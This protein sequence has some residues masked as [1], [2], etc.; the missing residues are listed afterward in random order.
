MNKNLSHLNDTQIHTLMKRYYNEESVSLLLEEF[1]IDISPS[2]LFKLFPPVVYNE[3]FCTYCP[4][5]NLA[6]E[7]KSR[8]NCYNENF[9]SEIF[10]PS[11]G[12]RKR[13]NCNCTK[14]YEV[15]ESQQKMTDN[16]KR[17]VIKKNFCNGKMAPVL[18][19]NLTLKDAI[20]LLTAVSHSAS[21]D[22]VLILPF[23]RNSINPPLAPTNELIS[24]IISYLHSKNLITVSA[25]S[26]LNAFNFNAEYEIESFY[27]NEVLWQLLPNMNINEKCTYLNSIRKIIEDSENSSYWN[28]DD[29]ASTWKQIV[30]Y[31]CI[32]YFIY[33]LAQRNFDINEIG[34]KTHLIFDNLLEN[35]SVGQIFNLSWQ[36]VRDTTDY[37]YSKNINYCRG[38]NTFIGAIQR[39]ADKALAEQWEVKGSRRDYACPRSVLSSIFFD[40]FL[41]LGEGYIQSISLFKLNEE[42]IES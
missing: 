15:K 38:R 24:N 41:R 9:T 16:I 30:K 42:V 14:C 18:I 32:E 26:N 20:Y 6:A 40:S 35:F 22:L 11:C 21:E 36:A 17:N 37:I 39:K 7:Y 3:L 34:E 10:C 23:E 31:E 8:A 12:H 19:E 25:T 28:E 29:I 33:L 5:V 4:N 13:Q 1:E 27:A 2:K